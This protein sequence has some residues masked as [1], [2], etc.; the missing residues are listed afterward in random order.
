MAY[1][2]FKY[3]DLIRHLG[4]TADGRR[5][6]DGVPPVAPSPAAAAQQPALTRLATMAHS[7]ASR[8][9]W[10]VGPLLGDFWARYDGRISLYAGVEFAAD[11]DAGLTGYVDF[12]LA[13]GPQLPPF[14][15][16]AP[17]LLVFEAKRDSIPDGLAQCVAAVAGA[18]R[19]NRRAGT[20]VDP[21]YGCVTTGSLWKFVR[22][23]GTAL[24]I[25]QDEYTIAQSAAILGILAHIVGPVPG[26]TPA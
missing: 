17:V 20:P 21:V 19:Y 26:A 7:E 13:R 6:F 23:S 2:D 18:D 25:D 8:A 11:P 4:L 24:T 10:M 1:S 3:T 14:Q 16:A 9:T 5:L 22:L 12:I 15:I